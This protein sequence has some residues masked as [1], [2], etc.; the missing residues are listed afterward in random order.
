M[1]KLR[2]KEVDYPIFLTDIDLSAIHHKVSIIESLGYKKMIESK[3]N[4]AK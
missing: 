3:L 4:K 1:L 2:Q